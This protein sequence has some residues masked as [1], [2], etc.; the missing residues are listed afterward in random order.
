[1]SSAEGFSLAAARESVATG[2]STL[3][4]VPMMS[5]IVSMEIIELQNREVDAHETVKA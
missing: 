4:R 3:W 2:F 5:P 1:M